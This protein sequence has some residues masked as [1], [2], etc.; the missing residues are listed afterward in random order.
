MP[1]QC[2]RY[3]A[4]DVLCGL[5]TVDLLALEPGPGFCFRERWLRKL[6]WKDMTRQLVYANPGLRPVRLT[7]EYDL[8]IAVCQN[9]WDLLYV[10]AVQGWRDHC[11]T[12]VL[13]LDELYVAGLARYKY[14]LPAL[15][16]FDHI[17][18]GHESSAAALSRIL[19]RKCHWV[20]TAVDVANFNPCPNA[21][22]RVIDVLSI[23]RRFEGVHDA[24]RKVT[25]GQR[26]FY[27]YDTLIGTSIKGRD[28]SQHRE[29][30]ANLVKRSKFFAVGPGMM[31]EPEVRAEPIVGLR[32][33]EGTAAGAVLI[34]QSP[35]CPAFQTLFGWPDVVIEMHPDG[36]DTLDVLRDLM[37]EPDRML[38]I[39][40][41]NAFEAAHRHDWVYRWKHIYEI[42]GLS[43]TPAMKSREQCL[44]EL[45]ELTAE[46]EVSAASLS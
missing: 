24:L 19:G 26:I 43:P 21:P 38:T 35:N 45:A 17:A 4:Q 25:A 23:G 22:A 34:G 37:A 14:W 41:R 11:R 2:N 33:Y 6:I 40:R 29:M 31:G 10:N 3:E 32:F 42:A 20:P 1:F 13:W 28:Y 18:L 39:S 16:Q 12:S 8:F 15:A 7:K 9:I 36:S 30:L 44:H 5:D 46:E 27:V